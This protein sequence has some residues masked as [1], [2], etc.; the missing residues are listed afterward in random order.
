M[1]GKIHGFFVTKKGKVLCCGS[2]Y[3]GQLSTGNC[4]G[5]QTKFEEVAKKAFGEKKIKQVKLGRYF[6]MV[7]TEDGEIYACGE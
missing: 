5:C 2:N 6:S 7:L 4:G 3:E 1:C